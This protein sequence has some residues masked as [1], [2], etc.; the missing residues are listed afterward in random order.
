MNFFQC[1]RKRDKYYY[2]KVKEETL[3]PL[4]ILLLGNPQSGKTGI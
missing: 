4:P 2:E 1:C 3:K